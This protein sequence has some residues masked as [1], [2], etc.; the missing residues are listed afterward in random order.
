M[1]TTPNF[2]WV[3]PA[4]TDF[5][6]DLPADFETFADAVDADVQLIKNT[7]DAA[8]PETLI[9]AAGDLIYGSAADTAARLAIGTAGQVLQVNSGATAPEWTTFSSGGMTVLASG[10]LPTGSGTLTLSSISSAYKDLRLVLRRFYPSSNGA[11]TLRLNN[12]AGSNTYSQQG[13]WKTFTGNTTAQGAVG[14]SFTI[15][16]DSFSS[17]ASDQQ[18]CVFNILDYNANGAYRACNWQTLYYSST[19]SANVVYDQV[20]YHTDDTVTNRIDVI[21][22]SNFAAGTYILYGIS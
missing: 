3:T 10:S 22:G 4:P 1:A 8:L 13:Q 9:D 6:T 14:N 7:A 16:Y 21:A 20:G 19:Q 17:S 15:G 11:I 2:G 12:G 18:H 5:V